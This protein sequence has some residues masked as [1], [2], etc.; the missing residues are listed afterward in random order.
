[1]PSLVSVSGV[2]LRC[3]VVVVAYKHIHYISALLG[4]CHSYI[5][6]IPPHFD[7]QKN[8]LVYVSNTYTP[9]GERKRLL[10][11]NC[12][13]NTL[14]HKI[15]IL[16]PFQALKMVVPGFVCSPGSYALIGQYTAFCCNKKR[17]HSVPYIKKLCLLNASSICSC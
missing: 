16:T 8:N 2:Y 11:C 12:S 1:M 14:I 17:V 4:F 15:K 6:D 5:N 13:P 3:C 7:T 10:K 9:Q